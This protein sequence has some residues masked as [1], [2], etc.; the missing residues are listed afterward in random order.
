VA[1]QKKKISINLVIKDEVESF[2][3]QLLSWIL[4]YG[5]YIIIITQIVV[6]SVFFLRFKL[7]RDHTDLKES[8]SQKQALIE[9]VGD[10]EAEIR[11]VQNTL[12]N[13]SQITKNQD[14]SLK[15]L[16]YLEEN[17]PSDTTFSKLSLSPDKISFSVT[18]SNL[19]SFNF[20]LLRLEKD[21]KLKDV[22]LEDIQTLP[23]GR[24][25][26]KINAII[27][28]AEFG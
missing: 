15:V 6:L 9:S 5:R 4:T 20:F 2:S 14:I 12:V 8:V 1:A 27:N 24:I 25:E 10:L 16:D 13:I 23:D 21:N 11:R 28:A 19:R 17:T 7:D 18:A 26:F 22:N 3:G